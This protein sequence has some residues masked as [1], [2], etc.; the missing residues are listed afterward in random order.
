VDNREPFSGT[1]AV[2]NG[3]VF[4]ATWAAASH[5]YGVR[6]YRESD[7]TE[8][9]RVPNINCL[10]SPIVADGVLYVQT[11]GD[12]NHIHGY[13]HAI[14]ATTGTQKWQLAIGVFSSNTPAF[15]DGLI[16]AT[17]GDQAYLYAIH[18]ENGTVLWKSE[19]PLNMSLMAFVTSP[20]AAD[21]VVYVVNNFAVFAYR[22]VDGELLWKSYLPIGMIGSDVALSDGV[23]YIGDNSGRLYALSAANGTA[24]WS[25]EW[26]DGEPCVWGTPAVANDTVYVNCVDG[27]TMSFLFAVNKD[28]GEKVWAVPLGYMASRKP[29]VVA[30]RLY[31]LSNASTVISVNLRT[32]LLEWNYSVPCSMSYAASGLE[33]SPAIGADNTI[34]ISLFTGDASTALLALRG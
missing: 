7:G 18:P 16:F 13:L 10:A 6:A 26:K 5:H 31:T 3:M 34:F 25:T 33:A 17:S 2:W 22:A 4:I 23:V 9:W 24:L 21:G 15:A 32:G 14:N 12:L 29:L 20:V 19:P 27:R 1:P 11:S 30:E 28:S 8:V